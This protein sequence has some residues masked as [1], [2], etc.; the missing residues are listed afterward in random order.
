MPSGYSFIRH[1]RV[2]N[3]MKTLLRNTVHRTSE[4][5]DTAVSSR[6]RRKQRVWPSG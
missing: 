1:A 5:Y 2:S 3:L 6:L 4:V